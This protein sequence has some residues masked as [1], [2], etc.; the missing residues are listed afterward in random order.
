M[1]K[2]FYLILIV[3][4]LSNCN[5]TKKLSLD[6]QDV[7]TAH[8]SKNDL[9]IKGDKKGLKELIHKDLIYKHSNCWEEDYYEF[10]SKDHVLKYHAIEIESVEAR[11]IE[12]IGIV[13][14]TALFKIEYKGKDLEL[15]LCYVEH[16]IWQDGK[17]ILISRHSSKDTRE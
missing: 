17:W 9:L 5:T 14:G 15:W 6:K 2:V 10:L 11:F 3:F 1:K 8:I 7:I 4:T 13:N 16:Y 12:N